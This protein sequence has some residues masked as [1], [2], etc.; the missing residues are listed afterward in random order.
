MDTMVERARAIALRAHQGQVD[1]AGR[2]YLAHPERVA[3]RVL[4]EGAAEA[5][6][7]L[8]DVLEDTEVTSADLSAEGIDPEVIAAVEA[9]TRLDGEPTESYYAR[10]AADPLALR[11]KLADLADNR[12]PARL[13]LLDAPV[14]DRLAA[15]YSHAAQMLAALAPGQAGQAD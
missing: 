12:D 14:R 8:H 6:A 10:V 13:A 5:V 1:K 15:K 2:S 7:W 3:Q 11:V 4:G 9:L